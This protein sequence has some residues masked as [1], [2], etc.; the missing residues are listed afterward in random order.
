MRRFKKEKPVV[1]NYYG[2]GV[3]KQVYPRNG[4]PQTNYRQNPAR[5]RPGERRT[6]HCAGAPAASAPAG[7]GVVGGL[8]QAHERSG[9]PRDPVT[10]AHHGPEATNGRCSPGRPW[11]R[12]RVGIDRVR[13]SPRVRLSQVQSG[14]SG[15]SVRNSVTPRSP[16]LREI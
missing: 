11:L 12:R 13:D 5:L 16:F 14:K 2:F 3:P 8:A 10:Q 4:A 9:D 6:P 15:Y 1:I 7:G